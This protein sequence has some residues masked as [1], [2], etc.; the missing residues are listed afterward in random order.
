MMGM[1]AAFLAL[2]LAPL[3]ASAT[4]HTLVPASPSAH[5]AQCLDAARRTPKDGLAAAQDWRD[6]GGGFPAA[7]CAAVALFGLKRYEDA[8]QAFEALAGAMMLR[9]P[10]L[11]AG[12]LA[13]AGQAWLLAAKPDKA[14]A[15]FDAALK[16]TPRDP[17]LF[18]DRAQA[19]AALGDYKT[20]VA[21]LDGALA[22]APGRADA[23]VLR[24]SAY[25][26]LGALGRAMKDVEAA[27][28][29]AP[30]DAAG[31]LE[32]GN[33]RRLQ[34]DDQGA[35]RDWQAVEAVAPGS[36]AAQSAK[37]NLARFDNEEKPRR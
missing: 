21:D 2:A 6:A 31:L 3:A 24:A 8:A 9:G 27:L 32:R 36:A 19:D 4:E 37:A 25:R 17:E 34:G 22:L 28:E 12:A 5:Y 23:L 14:R 35:R 26:R 11:R 16:Y 10:D 33:I 7:H 15:A 30:R 1:G 13:Q 29:A 20:A 18:I